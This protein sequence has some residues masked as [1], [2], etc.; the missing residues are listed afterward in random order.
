MKL[1]IQPAV[2]ADCIRQ[3]TG[4]EQLNSVHRAPAEARARKGERRSRGRIRQN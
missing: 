3:G 1:K 4:N 2:S